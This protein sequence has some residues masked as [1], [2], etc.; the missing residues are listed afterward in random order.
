MTKHVNE[1]RLQLGPKLEDY[2]ILP[3]TTLCRLNVLNVD[4]VELRFRE[5]SAV[6]AEVLCRKIGKGRRVGWEPVYDKDLRAVHRRN[7]GGITNVFWG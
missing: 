4:G 3:V 6:S 5:A 1:A 7:E 2:V